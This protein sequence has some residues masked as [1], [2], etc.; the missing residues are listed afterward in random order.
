MSGVQGVK[1]VQASAESPGRGHVR[2]DANLRG[3]LLLLGALLGIFI[4][5]MP[6]A[7]TRGATYQGVMLQIPELGIL[8]LAMALPLISGGL[9]LA[10]IATNNQ[11][12]LLM[13][14]ILTTQMPAE[15]AES[16]L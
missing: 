1:P 2:V 16:D 9:N 13:G 14:W 11:I 12:A 15:A 10:I 4:L 3:L 5:L 6:D 8:A 7:F